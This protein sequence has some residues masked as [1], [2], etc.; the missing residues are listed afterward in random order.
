MEFHSGPSPVE[1]DGTTINSGRESDLAVSRTIEL[2][3]YV[4]TNLL[5][6]ETGNVTK[7]SAWD[8]M[9]IL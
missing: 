7:C 3:H 6:T 1:T 9:P 8:K 4:A 2:S 5:T